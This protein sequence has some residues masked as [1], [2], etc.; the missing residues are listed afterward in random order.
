MNAPRWSLLNRLTLV[1]GTATLLAWCASSFWLYSAAVLTSDRLFDDALDNTANAV[2]AVVRNEISELNET[3]NGIG[4]ELAVIDQNCQ[5]DIVYQ[6]RGPNGILVFRS[7]GAPVAPL[8]G[9][10]D[11]GFGYATIG[12]KQYRVYTLAL[13][14]DA[15]TIHVAQPMSRRAALANSSALRLMAPGAAMMVALFAAIAWIA[16]KT[17]APIF[18]YAKVLDSLTPEAEK[19]VDGSGLPPE[20][21]SISEAVNRLTH[22]VHDSLIRERA[23]TADAAHELRNPLSAMLLKWWIRS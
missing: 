23:L 3:K 15:A 11:R 16:R 12:G 1:I 10:H 13:Q 14:L 20:L 18:G 2:L 21:L 22:R 17:T 6:V 4:L 8:A 9:A 7:H 5:S 19:P